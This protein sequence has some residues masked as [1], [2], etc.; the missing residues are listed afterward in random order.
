MALLIGCDDY[1]KGS[2]S[3]SNIPSVKDDIKRVSEF[4]TK[5]CF[6]VTEMYNPYYKDLHRYFTK[7]STIAYEFEEMNEGDR[8][9][10]VLFFC[11][12]SG[13]GIFN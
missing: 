1:E 6:E 7:L 13:H 11:Y 12:F 8:R 4:L 9:K 5:Y 10:G 3:L 2:T